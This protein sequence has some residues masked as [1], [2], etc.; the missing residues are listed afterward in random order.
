MTSYDDH[1]FDQRIVLPDIMNT[2]S[3]TFSVSPDA[4]GQVN[5]EGTNVSVH[6]YSACLTLI[7]LI[8]ILGNLLVIISVLKFKT[9]HTAINFLILGLA[10]ADLFVALFVMPYAVYI[11][12]QGGAWYLGAL[13]CD[14]YSASD[15]ACS[16][17]SIL[18]LTVISFDRYRAVSRP[19]QYSRQSKNIGRVVVFVIVIWVISLAL[20]SPVVLGAN[21]R[22]ENADEFECRFY[23]ADFSIYSSIVSFVIPCCVVLFVYIRIMIV[24][25]KREKAAR[26]RGLRTCRSSLN[27]E[28]TN[29][30]TESALRTDE[31]TSNFLVTTDDR[32]LT[33]S[34]LR[35]SSLDSLV[36]NNNNSFAESK[37][38]PENHTETDPCSRKSSE[39]FSSSR[40]SLSSSDVLEAKVKSKKNGTNREV[41]KKSNI[42]SAISL[43]IRKISQR[44]PAII[45]HNQTTKSTNV[46]LKKNDYLSVLSPNI[47]ENSF[48][49]GS[50]EIK[51]EL[52]DSEHT[53]HTEVPPNA[54]TFEKVEKFQVCDR[55]IRTDSEVIS[56]HEP[57][58]PHSNTP[59]VSN[60]DTSI[61]S[62]SIPNMPSSQQ[63]F[64]QYTSNSINEGLYGKERIEKSVVEGDFVEDPKVTA[65]SDETY[66]FDAIEQNT[67]GRPR[68]NT[69]GSCMAAMR[70]TVGGR[71][72]ITTSGRSFLSQTDSLTS[73]A[74]TFSVTVHELALPSTEIARR[75]SIN[76]KEN[77]A[78]DNGD[79]G[80]E[81][82]VQRGEKADRIFMKA[83]K[84]PSSISTHSF[85]AKPFSTAPLDKC[86]SLKGTSGEVSARRTVG[87]LNGHECLLRRHTDNLYATQK[88]Q[89]FS[90]LTRVNATN[91]FAARL[92][93]KTIAGKDGSLKSKM[94]KS[95]RKEKR[96]T[97]TLGIVVGIFLICWVPFFSMNILNAVCIKLGKESCQI[98]FG[99]FFYCTWI[100]YMNSFMNPI[101]YT[102]FNTEFRRAFRS[103]LLGRRRRSS[104]SSGFAMRLFSNLTRC[105]S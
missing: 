80:E 42:F 40:G 13:I 7:P 90:Y 53:D 5:S 43:R 59:S 79:A 21:V 58:N 87:H 73:P 8:T 99:T 3:T 97:K 54:R 10:F 9:L 20:A 15:V 78:D 84:I 85:V 63:H 82:N 12:I 101:I 45:H 98:G 41:R 74:V 89:G 14:I 96:A 72:R 50:D 62:K 103:I 1:Y 52:N 75:I 29:Y 70:Y 105:I 81:I 31:T 18:L 102:I 91:G 94:C 100:G 69:D 86:T 25:Q 38:N 27:A 56:H 24:L 44:S 71:S 55:N 23:N 47:I 2:T 37:Q 6:F 51:D 11:Y 76:N 60:T 17:A 61:A 28:S 46:I 26:Q 77:K 19:I 88:R 92:M 67:I 95:Q 66:S 65:K 32:E 34:S 57:S 39:I 16:T 36:N 30:C 64:Y 104:Q 4:P 22:P 48:V 83:W 68:C 49:D 93:K 33:G 35:P